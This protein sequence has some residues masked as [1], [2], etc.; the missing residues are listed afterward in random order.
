MD[1][2]FVGMA[3]LNNGTEVV[4]SR[5]PGFDREYAFRLARVHE[6]FGWDSVLFVYSSGAPDPTQAAARVAANTERLGLLVAHRPN[7]SY[8][9]YAAK[10]FATLDRISEGRLSVHLITGG[11]ASDQAAE[12]YFLDK[13]GRYRRTQEYIRIV[14]KV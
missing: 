7:V 14:K 8:P 3:C 1:K 9:A 6:D 13:A 4:T 12:G 5:S 10:A 11:T 2:Q